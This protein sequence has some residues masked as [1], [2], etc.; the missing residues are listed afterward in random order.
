M[1]VT[2]LALPGVLLIEPNLFRDQ[3]GYF[4]ETYHSKKYAE[5]GIDRPFVQDNHSRSAQG[6]L[7]GLHYQLVHP[8]GKLVRVVHGIVFDVAVDVRRESPHFGQ[9]VGTM[10]SDENQRQLYVPPGYAH[11]FCVLSESADFI[12]KCT[13]FYA[14][15]DEFG[16]A[17][18]DP[19]I[20]VDWPLRDVLLSDKDA[21]LPRLKDAIPNLPKFEG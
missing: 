6:T 21:K 13:D 19:D 20:A 12:Y 9:W 1:K 14:P 5:I 16:V 15:G 17:W 10:L 18:N 2:P 7:R 8:Q 11:G 3:R 4:Q